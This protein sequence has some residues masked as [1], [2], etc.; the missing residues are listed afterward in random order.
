M[1]CSVYRLKHARCYSVLTGSH[2]VGAALK[3]TCHESWCFKLEEAT[4]MCATLMHALN[5]ATWPRD[6]RSCHYT[7]SVLPRSP[8]PTHKKKKTERLL[9]RSITW[10]ISRDITEPQSNSTKLRIFT[11]WYSFSIDFAF[12]YRIQ[13]SS[14]ATRRCVESAA[15]SGPLSVNREHRS[16][17]PTHSADSITQ[18]TQQTL[19]GCALV[20]HTWEQQPAE[21]QF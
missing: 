20:L 9:V 15:D 1:I 5:N 18:P 8:S 14:K 16:G 21:I 2:C 3:V 10:A 13:F 12:G 19:F 6:I 7:W 4:T 11:L 17:A